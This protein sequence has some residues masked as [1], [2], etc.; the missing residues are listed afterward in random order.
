MHLDTVLTMVDVDAVTLYPAVIEGARTWS[1]RPGTEAGS[2]TISEN[3]NGLVAALAAAL[4]R[5]GI[6]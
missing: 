3:S 1:L 2:V 5:A 6:R 4:G